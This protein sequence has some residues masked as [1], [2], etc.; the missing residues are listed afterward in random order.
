MELAAALDSVEAALVDADVVLATE[1]SGYRQET[2]ARTWRGQVLVDW[3]PDARAG[4]CLLRPALLRRL[5]ALHASA[6]V[7]GESVRISAPGRIVAGVSDE[8][9]QLVRRLGGARR[10]QLSATLRFSDG[11]YRGGEEVYA[12][13]ERGQSRPLLRL[14]V[15]ISARAASQRT[16]PAPT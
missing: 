9:A 12:I 2:R 16:S 7:G 8:H 6:E 13:V 10:V 11:A 1:L 15:E 4:D 14:S 5:V 3:E